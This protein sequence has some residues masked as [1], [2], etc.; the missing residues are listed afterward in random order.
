L[1][2]VPSRA[3]LASAESQFDA[4]TRAVIAAGHSARLSRGDPVNAP[5]TLETV[6]PP[7]AQT[8]ARVR[9]LYSLATRHALKFQQSTFQT[10]DDSL[11]G[12][13]RVQLTLPVTATYPELR[14]FIEALL[15]E[16]PYVTVDQLVF[17]RH[18]I[19]ENQI[20]AEL[21]V[22]CWF[23]TAAYPASPLTGE[24]ATS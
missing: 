5:L 12:I 20:E 6:L 19:G 14:Q 15:R 7:V 16:L 18:N 10:N 8:D 24:G 2:I 22:S 3:E 9:R 13:S 23:R 11:I 1:Q 4:A 17:K 21:H